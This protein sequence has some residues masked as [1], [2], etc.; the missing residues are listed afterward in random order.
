MNETYYYGQGKVFLA[1]RDNNGRPGSWRWVGDVSDFAITLSFEQ[2]IAKSSRAGKL[3]STRRYMTMQAGSIN[4]TW[5]DF[6]SE[7]L[8]LLLNAERIRNYP[9]I[10]ESED[11]P[12]EIE[13][14]DRI[15]LAYQNVWGVEIPG[16][17]ID[18]DFTVEP[19]WGVINFLKTPKNQP[20]HVNYAHAN[21]V[22]IPIFTS[23]QEEFALRYESINLAENND[24]VLIEL[25]RLSFNPL[26][27]LQLI[28]TDSSLA[29]IET[30][31]E[32]MYDAQRPDDP[33]LGHFGKLVLVEPLSGITHD[34]SIYHN[35]VHTHGGN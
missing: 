29:G 18:V 31:A 12:N 17:V 33:L 6:S 35:G 2:K 16:A 9:E 23:L 15:S 3:V 27:T 34:G 14:G 13:A 8:S 24:C 11:L 19:S 7:N 21:S 5:H 32:I 26:T 10:I 22:S 25:Y 30:T 28:N 20:V 1:R 4:S